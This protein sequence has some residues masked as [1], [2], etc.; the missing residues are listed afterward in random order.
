LVRVLPSDAGLGLLNT[1]YS[2]IRGV[3]DS[4]PRLYDREHVLL[5]QLYTSNI[6]I[7]LASQAVTM[8]DHKVASLPLLHVLSCKHL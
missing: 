3:P 8:A 2:L 5:K 7:T 1:P 4:S 6:Q